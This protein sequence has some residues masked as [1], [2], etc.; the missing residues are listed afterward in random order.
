M[1]REQQ[2]DPFGGKTLGE[3]LITALEEALAFER[4]ELELRTRTVEIPDRP[5]EVQAPP[6]FDGERV[7][8]VRTK[9]AL[10][11]QKFAATLNVSPQTV[12]AWERGVRRPEGSTLRL[13]E[14][15]EEHPE[16]LL[17]TAMPGAARE[18]ETAGA[19]R[20]AG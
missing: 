15:A 13:L 3:S 18:E 20:R 9:L 10:S 12:K 14:I 6:D 5:S 16:A 1:A 7:R 4:G 8:A 11:P 17:A 19:H 2:H